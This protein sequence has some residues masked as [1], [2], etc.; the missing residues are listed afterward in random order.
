ML[1]QT[2]HFFY[3]GQPLNFVP[4]N[5]TNTQDAPRVLEV[6]YSG[7]VTD[8]AAMVSGRSIFGTMTTKP[9]LVLLAEERAME[10]DTCYQ[11]ETAQLLYARRQEEARGA[12][13]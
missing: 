6:A 8:R 12:G 3:E 1:E 13:E 5:A 10:I 11:F 9:L 4:K 2:G 7:A